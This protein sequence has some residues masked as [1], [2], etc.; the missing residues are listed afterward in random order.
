MKAK[1][2]YQNLQITRDQFINFSL[3]FF[4]FNEN[5]CALFSL[6]Q[7]GIKAN[8]NPTRF[9]PL[10][11]LTHVILSSNFALH[12]FHPY[13]QV[14]HCL[15]S[16]W[17]APRTHADNSRIRSGGAVNPSQAS[18]WS[19]AADRTCISAHGPEG[20]EGHHIKEAHNS[21]FFLQ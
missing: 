19:S 7:L 6:W 3:I 17:S 2:F 15:H 21:F 1:I 5:S 16:A 11:A 9:S 10:S 8:L 13:L 4:F 18:L 14:E 20:E 12:S